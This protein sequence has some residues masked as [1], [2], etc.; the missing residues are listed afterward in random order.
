MEAMEYVITSIKLKWR[1]SK[2]AEQ[3]GDI[4][5]DTILRDNGVPNLQGKIDS[6]K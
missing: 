6:I 2:F 4:L 1:V 5:V 3:K